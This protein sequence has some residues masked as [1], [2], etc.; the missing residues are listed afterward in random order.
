MLPKAGTVWRK[1]TTQ[2]TDTLHKSAVQLPKP[3][4]SPET[5]THELVTV[6]TYAQGGPKKLDHF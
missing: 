5:A 6:G 2:A 3:K 1:I 4:S